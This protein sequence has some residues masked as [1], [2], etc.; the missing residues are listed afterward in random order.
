M[1]SLLLLVSSCCCS[2]GCSGGGD[3]TALEGGGG[4]GGATEI[5]GGGGGG[6]AWSRERE[7]DYSILVHSHIM[8]YCKHTLETSSC[9][10]NSTTIVNN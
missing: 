5:G 9:Y 1:L 2:W 4:G 7:N 3:D 10:T 8:C 6:A